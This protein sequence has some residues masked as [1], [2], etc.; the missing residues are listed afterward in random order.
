M[1][2]RSFEYTV[3]WSTYDHKRTQFCALHTI[4]RE[5][6][7]VHVH[8]NIW[9]HI[10]VLVQKI[11]WEQSSIHLRMVYLDNSYVRVHKIG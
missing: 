4:I 3:L 11:I 7:S 10:S 9:E 1:W 5:H 6:S 8:K 2:V